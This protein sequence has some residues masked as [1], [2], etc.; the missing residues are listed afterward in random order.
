MNAADDRSCR[1]K[2]AV[3]AARLGSQKQY[4]NES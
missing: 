4:E 2:E 1:R 3:V